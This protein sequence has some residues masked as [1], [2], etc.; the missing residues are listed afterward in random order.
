MEGAP[1]VADGKVYIGGGNA[2]VIC[3]DMNHVTLNGQE[4]DLTAAQKAIDAKWQQLAAQ[5]E[6][7]KKKDPDF[8]IPPS[9]DALPKP[10]P[11]KL[12]QVGQDK[13]HV[14]ASLAVV[15]NRVLVASAGLDAE[16]VGDRAL[17]CLDAA[18]GA[19][20]WRTPLPLNPWAG[21][22]VAK[23]LVV[24]GCS[25]IRFDPKD[26]PNGKGDVVAMDLS[27]GQIKWKK[28]VAGGVIS[29]IAIV[30]DL[31]ICTATDCKVRALKLADGQVTWEYDAKSALFAGP[32]VAAG[33]AYV[34]DLKGM[35]HAIGLKD[36]QKLWTLDLAN[37]PA[38]KAP[39]MV[40]GS[41]LLHQGKL[42][43]GTCNLDTGQQKTVVVCIE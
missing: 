15:G 25:N 3:V 10:Q 8:A 1:T 11:K 43:L 7:D 4:T 37:D 40:F 14:D 5:Y 6:M 23:D 9:E 28:E 19:T 18:T 24:I 32:A 20:Q 36:G 2:G 30:D 13:L 21:P 39:G 34:A 35:V 29:P 41:P 27:S 22:S 17:L 38:V 31:A 26:I 42:Y 33:M 12:W 16:K